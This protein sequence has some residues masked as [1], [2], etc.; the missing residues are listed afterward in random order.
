MAVFMIFVRKT[1]GSIYKIQKPIIHLAVKLI[2]INIGNQMKVTASKHI[3]IFFSG[4][5]PSNILSKIS[6]QLIASSNMVCLSSIELMTM[7]HYN[8]VVTK[9]AIIHNLSRYSRILMAINLINSIICS[10]D[11]ILSSEFAHISL[12]YIETLIFPCNLSAIR[13]QIIETINTY[14]YLLIAYVLYANSSDKES[15]EC[16]YTQ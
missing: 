4:F 7:D 8:I 9:V 11:I 12:L 10:F 16:E 2:F 1:Y 5:C 6:M 15:R 13:I 3:T 14:R